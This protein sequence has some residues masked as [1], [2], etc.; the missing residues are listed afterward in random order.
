MG[1]H[2]PLARRIITF[3]LGVGA[4]IAAY[5]TASSGLL[6]AASLNP[7]AASAAPLPA[8]GSC[9]QLRSWY[10]DQALPKVGPW[11]LSGPPVMYAMERGAAA[12]QPVPAQGAIG[13][14]RTG[15]NVQE[16]GVD[17]S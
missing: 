13:S 14:S 12:G 5:A 3:A 4:G 9:D 6:G 17:E 15:T 16:A 11:G 2:S 7:P 10:A 1:P 8:F